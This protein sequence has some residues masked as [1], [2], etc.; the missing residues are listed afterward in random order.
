MDPVDSVMVSELIRTTELGLS[1]MKAILL[2]LAFLF[3]LTSQASAQR[4]ESY[5][6]DEEPEITSSV[7][8]RTGLFVRSIE[9]SLK[10][11]HD[12]L[13]LNPYYVR[14]HLKDARLPAFSGLSEDQY[15]NL[16]VV[17]TETDSG[18]S[19]ITGYL[20]LSEVRNADGSPA[21]FPEMPEGKPGYG[22]VTLMFLVEDTLEIYRK[23]E[24]AGYEVISAPERI[25]GGGNTQLLMRGPDGEHIWLTESGLRTRPFLK[26]V[27][28]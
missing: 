6:P 16:T 13:G 27:V 23:V 15:M 10:F 4:F 19:L 7:I 1:S 18:V 11:Y 3:G 17:R 5:W 21:V 8:F 28:E 2:F 22:T 24:A 14:T 25:E 26:E 9:E 12:I 20:G